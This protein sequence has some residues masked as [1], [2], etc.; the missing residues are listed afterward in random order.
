MHMHP[1]CLRREILAV[2]A[3]NDKNRSR[4]ADPKH[5]GKQ[6]QRSEHRQKTIALLG[7]PH[8]VAKDRAVLVEKRQHC[9]SPIG[10]FLFPVDISLQVLA[11]GLRSCISNTYQDD[12]VPKV[13]CKEH[14]AAMGVP[15]VRYRFLEELKA[16]YWRESDLASI[17]DLLFG[18]RTVYCKDPNERSHR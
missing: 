13:M 14:L 5:F 6:N 3:K 17:V 11:Y 18:I 10:S 4:S 8:E 12:E 9:G 1:S 15:R 16:R 2:P 7:R